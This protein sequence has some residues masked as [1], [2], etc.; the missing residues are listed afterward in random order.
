MI[1]NELFFVAVFIL[2]LFLLGNCIMCII[3]L[4]HSICKRLKK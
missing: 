2:L 4:I 3:D 1:S